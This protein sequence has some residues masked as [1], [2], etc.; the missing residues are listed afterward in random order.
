MVRT[1][2]SAGCKLEQRVV[3]VG[4]RRTAGGDAT[5]NVRREN[6]PPSGVI[7]HLH[8]AR[9]EAT[10]CS[11]HRALRRELEALRERASAAASAWL[12][13]RTRLICFRSVVL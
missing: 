4:R 3:G 7:G 10:Y 9:R 6:L 8:W 5:R 12:S 13:E 1:Y 2:L 11:A